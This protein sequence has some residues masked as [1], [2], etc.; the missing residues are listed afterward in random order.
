[1]SGD[2]KNKVHPV[3]LIIFL[4]I[5]NLL[6]G[7]SGCSKSGM[8]SKKNENRSASPDSI[9]DDRIGQKTSGSDTVFNRAV[10]K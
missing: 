10:E 2:K 8:V 6:S 3:C 9:C 4:L 1:M 7:C 5:I